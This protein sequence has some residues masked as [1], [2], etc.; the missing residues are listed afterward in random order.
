MVRIIAPTIVLVGMRVYPPYDEQL[1]TI[2]ATGLVVLGFL[3]LMYQA[4]RLERHPLL[5]CMFTQHGDELSLGGALSAL[6]PKVIA[7]AVILVPVLFPDF[8]A[9]MQSLVRSIT[10]L[11]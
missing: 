1:Q 4:L 10:S 3:L 8:M 6:W 9:W 2:V 11:Q 5:G 7:A